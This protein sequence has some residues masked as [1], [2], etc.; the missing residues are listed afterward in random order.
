NLTRPGPAIDIRRRIDVGA[1][2]E[3]VVGDGCRL[4]PVEAEVPDVVSRGVEAGHVPA[5]APVDEGVRFHGP[6]RELVLVLLVVLEREHPAPGDGPGD[7]GGDLRVVAAGARDLEPLFGG[8][9]A[10]RGDDLGA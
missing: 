9:L 4:D 5:L 8:V 1:R 3:A 10:E 7:D 2:P 6:G